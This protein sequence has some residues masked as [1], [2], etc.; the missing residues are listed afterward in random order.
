MTL[1]DPSDTPERQT[2]KL[3]RIAESLMRRV[4]QSPDHSNLAYA[5]FERAARLEGEVRQRTADLERTLDLLHESNARLA[6]S[7]EEAQAAQS[8]LA[9]AIETVEEGFALFDADDRLVLNNSRF[10]TDLGDVAGRLRPGLLFADYVDLVSRSQ[11]LEL[12]DGQTRNEWRARRLLRHADSH[13][14][15][16]VRLSLD[17]WIQVSEHRTTSGGT[18]ILQTD[19]TRVIR[20][21]RRERDR[22]IDRRARIERA[23]LDH[24]AQGVCTFD[25][26]GK[27]VGW[28]AQMEAILAR[29]L[30]A[31]QIGSR[32]DQL[33]DRL[34]DM[35][36]FT[37]H[38]D[39]TGLKAWAARR[40]H[41]RDLQFEVLQGA[42]TGTHR[43]YT[44]SAQQMPD[45]GFVISFTDVTSERDSARALRDLNETLERRV[46]ARTDELG[47]ALDEARRANASKT[48]FMA[49]ASH[50]LLQ[51]L[52]A[53]K[54]FVSAIEDRTEEAEIGE[55]AGKAIAAL[56]SVETFIEALLDISKLDSGRVEL[57]VEDTP[58]SAILGSLA[59]EM[60]PLAATKGITL[61]FVP[62]TLSVCSDPVL[63]R[64]MIQNLVANA[65]RHTDGDRVLVGVRREDG[66]ARIEVVDK[67]PGIPAEHQKDIFREFHQLVPHRSGAG[68][69]GLGLA[70][71]ERAADSLG[72]GLMLRSELGRGSR[73]GVTVP[74]V[75]GPGPAATPNSDA[76]THASRPALSG[77]VVFLVENDA[78]VARGIT[79]MVEG[80]GAD[81]IHAPDAEAGLQLLEDLG[82]APDVFLVDYQLGDGM[83]GLE[84]I[85]H[86][87]AQ[88]GPVAARL[89]SAD[90]SS[91][92][93][94]ACEAAQV[95]LIQKP[96]SAEEVAAFLST[97]VGSP[98]PGAAA[99]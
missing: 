99:S 51:P 36:T 89:I 24:L 8:N 83:D 94:R 80:W 77:L 75:S 10:C 11:S 40:G 91:A 5:Q 9:E 48:R 32:F 72:H 78:E 2:A 65:I 14:T 37:G 39:R 12:P 7:I 42:E 41:R 61:T 68:G 19:V 50:D 53:A 92:L 79:L 3:L 17:R 56:A 21:E 88:F 70:I 57:S 71:V 54:L 31:R 62:T 84:M 15:F 18:V 4:E 34:A 46:A 93:Q 81:L 66:Q 47:A 1:I 23:T 43:I 73:F 97:V 87:R 45:G 33:L 13:T 98:V 69:L 26:D 74:I 85:D 67:G 35:F 44:V 82:I 63:L 60:T 20:S 58:L 38:M 6:E 55:V 59:L 96:L 64:R 76:A 16:N 29:P 90:R 86:L 28:N 49:A 95:R 52:S 22:L 25:R 30:G 27:L